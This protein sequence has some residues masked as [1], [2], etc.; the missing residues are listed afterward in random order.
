[1]FIEDENRPPKVEDLRV[2]LITV[3]IY[4]N[5]A[6][7]NEHIKVLDQFVKQL[8]DYVALTHCDVIINFYTKSIDG[9]LKKY[10]EIPLNQLWHLN[11]G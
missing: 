8:T 2:N 5:F 9:I 3:S 1:M 11:Q 10:D 4:Y 7:K 6:V